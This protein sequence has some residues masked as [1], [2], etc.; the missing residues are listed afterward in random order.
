MTAVST[1]LYHHE[2]FLFYRSI[3]AVGDRHC[4]SPKSIESSI[5][6]SSILKITLFP[7]YISHE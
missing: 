7:L 1:T 5:P 3:A 2:N 6:Q 4:S